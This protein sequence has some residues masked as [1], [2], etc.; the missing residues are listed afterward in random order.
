MV[1]GF[2]RRRACGEIR[3]QDMGMERTPLWNFPV[4]FDAPPHIY[5]HALLDNH[6]EGGAIFST[7]ETYRYV[8]WR[9]WDLALPIWLFGMLNP[10]N[11]T[12][13]EPD[14]TVDKQI[15]RARRKNAGGIVV[16]NS[17]AVREQDRHKAIKHSDPIGPD[18]I[19]WIREAIPLA[20]V[21]ILAHGAD[22]VKFGGDLIFREAF[23]EIPTVALKV[24]KNGWPAH[25]L[26]LKYNLPLIP[27]QYQ[28]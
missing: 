22:A 18:N 2:G 16:V 12:H 24:T 6:L 15:E 3:F 26:Y 25:P 27:F 8:L 11:A 23:R 1:R 9:I 7:C 14:N 21:H 4:S 20:Q 13:D 28:D 5:R 17:G 19:Y 10:S